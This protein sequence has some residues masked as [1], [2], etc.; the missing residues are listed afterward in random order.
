MRLDIREARIAFNN[1][2]FALV[3]TTILI[4]LFGAFVLARANKPI[5][6]SWQSQP[7]RSPSQMTGVDWHCANSNYFPAR[8]Q[9]A[10]AR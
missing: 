5:E 1:V 4:A 9:G 10:R 6:C 7:G 8:Q 2:F 3:A